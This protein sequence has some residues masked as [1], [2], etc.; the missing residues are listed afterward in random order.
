MAFSKTF[1][2]SLLFSFLTSLLHRVVQNLHC[3]KI[4]SS[5]FQIMKRFLFEQKNCS[6]TNAVV[7][8]SPF[9]GPIKQNFVIL[10]NISM[11]FSIHFFSIFVIWTKPTKIFVTVHAL[12]YF[13]GSRSFKFKHSCKKD[14]C[15]ALFCFWRKKRQN[16]NLQRW[17]WM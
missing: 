4:F 11:N 3:N 8:F 16:N 1:E 10:T 12:C 7:I 2:T 14:V 9:F 17:K 6:H 5:S 15:F 13:T